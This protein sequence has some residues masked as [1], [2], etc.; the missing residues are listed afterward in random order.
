MRSTT[1]RMQKMHVR[2]HRHIFRRCKPNSIVEEDDDDDEEEEEGTLY[3]L[4]RNLL[5]LRLNQTVNVQRRTTHTHERFE[6]PGRC[7]FLYRFGN[8][9]G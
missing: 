8:G 9:I 7:I 5:F 3:V 2:R 1:A 4:R 6:R